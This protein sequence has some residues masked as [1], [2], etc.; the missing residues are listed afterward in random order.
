M[1]N[2]DERREQAILRLKAKRGFRANLVTY[3]AINVFLVIVWAFSGAGYFWPIWVM[4]GWGL[5]IVFHAWA[6]YGRRGISEA[7]V[8][9]EMERGGDTAI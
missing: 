1:A 9:R 6:I 2:E 4:A 8:Q 5:A 3:A 7:D